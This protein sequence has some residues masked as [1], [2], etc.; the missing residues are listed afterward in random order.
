MLVCFGDGH[1]AFSDVANESVD[2]LQS[3]KSFSPLAAVP[4]E[5]IRDGATLVRGPDDLLGDLGLSR[6]TGA[7]GSGDR[8]LPASERAVWDAL[9]TAMAADSLAGVAGISLP[10]TMSALVALEL[11]GRVRQAGG[12]Y[13]RRMEG[14]RA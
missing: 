11:R 2:P 7:D 13:E 8:T 3:E 9:T 6:H 1:S 5:L 4:L 10:E 12:R 14:G